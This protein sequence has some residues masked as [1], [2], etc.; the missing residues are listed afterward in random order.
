MAKN[1]RVGPAASL[2]MILGMILGAVGSLR[3]VASGVIDQIGS[4]RDSLARERALSQRTM[5]PSL[6][7]CQGAGLA[8]NRNCM[9]TAFSCSD[10]LRVAKMKPE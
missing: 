3:S 2:V 10:T 9:P 4:A 5:P 6:R 1:L 7:E 8:H